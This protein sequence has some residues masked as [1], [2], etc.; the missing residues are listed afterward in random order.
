MKED[1]YFNHDYNAR[2][3]RKIRNMERFLGDRANE[4]YGTFWKLIEMLAAET[5]RWYLPK[6]YVGI[7][8]ELRTD[9]T[10]I[11][12]IVEDFELFEHDEKNFWNKRLD[13]HFD[14]R[15]KKSK[16]AK[17]AVKV[18]WQKQAEA[19]AKNTTEQTDA[20]TSV[21]NPNYESD[22]I[23]ERKGKESKG[24][25][26]KEKK[27]TPEDVDTAKKFYEFK[28]DRYNDKP[29]QEED[30]IEK[31][32]DEC[33][34]LR[35]NYNADGKFLLVILAWFA[36]QPSKDAK[37]WESCTHSPAALKKIDGSGVRRIDEIR[38]LV[39]RDIGNYQQTTNPKIYE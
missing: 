13:R 6:D 30:R 8:Y 7:A 26:K 14:E 37:F 28:K 16:L 33:R 35:E 32:A 25:D 23:K 15:A 19:K 9:E 27:Y 3:D 18:R 21:S 36:K 17:K 2:A 4:G 5:G 20:D 22:T 24:K 31:W 1:F 10:I 29:K 11:Q 12:Q 38:R 39:T 34:I